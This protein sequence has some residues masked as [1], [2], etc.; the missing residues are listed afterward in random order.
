MPDRTQTDSQV[1]LAGRLHFNE[2]EGG[3]W[4]LELHPAPPSVGDHVVLVGADGAAR[5]AGDGAA[6]VVRGAQQQN[7]VDFL[8][9]G[10]RFEVTSLE[11]QA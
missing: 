8:M 6:V 3:F 2:I 5:A 9:A 4:T 7:V 11:V 10:P 1:E